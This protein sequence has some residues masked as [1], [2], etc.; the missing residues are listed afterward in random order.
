MLW[1]IPVFG[2]F[3]RRNSVKCV[4]LWTLYLMIFAYHSRGR[5]MFTSPKILHETLQRISNM[6]KS[7]RAL[8]GNNA[9]RRFF[10]VFNT[11]RNVTKHWWKLKFTYERN[12]PWIPI[13]SSMRCRPF[14]CDKYGKLSYIHLLF[15]AVAKGVNKYLFYQCLHKQ[16]DT[17]F[18]AFTIRFIDMT[19]NNNNLLGYSDLTWDE[20]VALYTK[21]IKTNSRLARRVD[22]SNTESF[23][24]GTH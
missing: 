21:H 19:L 18:Q 3:Y 15:F 7:Y 23:T 5:R 1:N 14:T 4:S 2:H 9:E 6:I 20:M 11:V 13:I 24:F 8:R 16:I 10:L 12:F 22:C 17:E